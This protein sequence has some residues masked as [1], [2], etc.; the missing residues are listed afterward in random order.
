MGAVF[1]R[2]HQPRRVDAVYD[3]PTNARRGP[4]VT[5]RDKAEYRG[6]VKTCEQWQAEFRVLPPS[7]RR[8]YLEEHSGLPGPR[9]NTTL[10][11]AVAGMA[12]GPLIRELLDSGD[13]FRM[14]CGAAAS[15]ARGQEPPFLEDAHALASDDRW[16]VREGVAL[17]L[18]LLGDTDPSALTSIVLTWADD[19]DP[20]VQR[21]AAAAICEPRLLHAPEAAAI[22]IV[23]C[24]RTTSHLLRMPVDK[25]STPPVRALRQALGYCWSVAVAADP[26]RGLPAFESLDTRDPDIEWIVSQNSRKKR[27]ARLL[28]PAP[29]DG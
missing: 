28:T 25:R 3:V 6:G 2:R 27:L 4:V 18:Q 21:A 17:G 9:A 13:E 19:P 11:C 14:M 22:A 29:A 8:A 10:A 26:P 24:R 5:M 1:D 16:R 23:V 15:A 12:D 20:L 7:A